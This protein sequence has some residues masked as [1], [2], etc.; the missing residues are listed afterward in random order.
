VLFIVGVGSHLAFFDDFKNFFA[1]GFVLPGA[2]DGCL[3]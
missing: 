1:V 2:E 3:L